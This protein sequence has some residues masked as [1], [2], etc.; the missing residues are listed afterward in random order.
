[1]SFVK[2]LFF[3]LIL[4]T[5]AIF[6]LYVSYEWMCE[7]VDS[8]SKFSFFSKSQ[9]AKD[10]LSL[11]KKYKLLACDLEN[12]FISPFAIWLEAPKNAMFM[13]I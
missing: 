5:V 3:I 1:M 6:F 2:K 4:G 8:S 10:S 11:T 13:V 9:A 12:F 7:W